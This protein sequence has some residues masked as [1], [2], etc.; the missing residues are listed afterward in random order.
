M[1]E[2]RR[3]IDARDDGEVYNMM[4]DLHEESGGLQESGSLDST[5]RTK[6]STQELCKSFAMEGEPR[7]S[8][9]GMASTFSAGAEVPDSIRQAIF[10][11]PK[12]MEAVR[13]SE[14]ARTAPLADPVVQQQILS[15]CYERHPEVAEVAPAA[16]ASWGKDPQAQKAA[17]LAA[18]VVPVLATVAGLFVG[19][20]RGVELINQGSPVVRLLA[21]IG[22]MS[23]IFMSAFPIINP[24]LLLNHPV[25]WAIHAYQLI[26]SVT[27]LIFEAKPE[28]VKSLPM[29]DDY[30]AILL[31]NAKFLA[32]TLG[33]GMFYCFQGTLWLCLGYSVPMAA[34]TVNQGFI[35]KTYHFFSV[36]LGL[37]MVLLGG[38]H[39]LMH[40]GIMPS[41]YA[42][43]LNSAG[44]RASGSVQTAMRSLRARR[45]ETGAP[46]EER[47]AGVE[48]TS[49]F[50]GPSESF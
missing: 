2:E 21:F 33:R 47:Q 37:Y 5:S 31:D 12:V 9:S 43:S 50:R 13:K 49:S 15:V 18:G 30:K 42:V 3:S 35:T 7:R 32:K 28:W 45:T 29:L 6:I 27:T 22:G 46:Q 34:A 11:H 1:N 20:H 38:A 41:H 23:C 26:F 25:M 44:E 36:I 24:W 48:L 17:Q 40:Y 19:D 4:A 16:I 14:K 8:S 10:E 39:I